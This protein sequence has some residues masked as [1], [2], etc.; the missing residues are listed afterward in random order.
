MLF[1]I[2]DAHCDYLYNDVYNGYDISD[3]VKDQHISLASLKKGNVKLQ[4]FAVW[5]DSRIKYPYLHQAMSMIDACH[6][7]VD[8]YDELCWFD[9]DYNP[10]SDK[11]AVVLTLEGGEAIEGSLT[12]LRNFYRLGARAMTFTW[13]HTN[14][15]AQPAMRKNAKGLTELGKEVLYEMNEIGMAV[16]VSHLSDAGI[17]DCLALSTAPIFASHTN[18]RSIKAHARNMRDDHIREIGARGGVIGVNFYIPHLTDDAKP[19]VRQVVDHIEHIV[20]LGG[21][22]CPVLGSDF[23]GMN[24]TIRDLSTSADMQNITIELV[25]RGFNDDEVLRI[26]YKNLRDYIARFF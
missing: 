9:S 19:S 16:D 1:P 20:E 21:I 18:C 12:N 8:A 15:L 23:D 2:A 10:E 4:F 5:V 11:T 26:C 22:G 14:S 25:R 17:D 6:L 3:P 7:I 24:P 13:N